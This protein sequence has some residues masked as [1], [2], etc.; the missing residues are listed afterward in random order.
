MA[1]TDKYVEKAYNNLIELSADELKWLDYEEREKAI[2]DYNHQMK[3]QFLDGKEEGIKKGIDIGKREGSIQ[4]L[5]ETLQELEIS[6]SETKN[7]VMKKFS[8]SEE[9]AERCIGKCW[10]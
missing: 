4:T 8:V 1:K 6:I 3:Y 10:K 7:R 9:E 5:I 2:R